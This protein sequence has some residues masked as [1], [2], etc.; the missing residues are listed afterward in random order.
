MLKLIQNNTAQED[1]TEHLL[2]RASNQVNAVV[3]LGKSLA[4]SAQRVNEHT[5]QQAQYTTA[6]TNA[7][8]EMCRSI[9]EIA[10]SAA[11]TSEATA[12]MSTLNQSSL[13][14]M[15]Q[16]AES[17]GAV[18]QLFDR[19]AN[20]MD[21]LRE[22]SSAVSQVV[23][24]ISEIAAQTKLLSMNASIETAHA[25][26]HGRGFAVVAQEVRQ[27]AEKTRDS[28]T[29]ITDVITH[30]LE[31]TEE[32]AGVIRDGQRNAQG[33]VEQANDTTRA[34]LTVSNEIDG[35]NGMIVKI[36][37]AAEEQSA[38]A[39]NITGNIANVARLA[40]DAMGQT[41]S[42]YQTSQDLARIASRLEDRLNASFG[43]EFFGVVP[44]ENAIKLNK[45]F[46][47]LCQVVSAIL[48]RQLYVRLGHDYENA[49][50]DI[51]AGRAL[52][53]YQ[54]PSTYIEAHDR[55]G[56]VPL[57]VPLAKGEP[58]YRSAIVVREESGI[59]SV[60]QLRGKRFAFG[61][62][63]S[64]G[65]K[66]MPQSML[67]DAGVAL[68]DLAAHGFLGSHDNVANAVMQNEFDGGGLM[69]SVAEKY[70][71]KGL[72]IIETS[73][74][75]PQFPLCASPRLTETERTKLTEALVSIQD[76]KVLSSLGSGIS[77][78]APIEDK[79]YDSVRVMLK[80]LAR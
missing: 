37:A 63:K 5:G 35:V 33:S 19:I 48:G 32:M 1:Q 38:T 51:G 67:H 18:S 36:A 29:E 74:L 2:G 21:R 46:A 65:S 20:A 6:L 60:A 7:M 58:Y 73:P 13:G 40:N 64:T 8:E 69:L 24:V 15:Q 17:V 72:K 22:A 61:D 4:E 71:G 26:D 34:L 25:G 70:I 50:K 30:N 53:S 55:Y 49:I 62:P 31:L 59:D 68:E 16:L 79:D 27:L 3:L 14:D 42:S 28:V 80:R 43:M 75:I 52:I 56:V 39:E 76:S 66:A 47:P 44:L 77:G 11:T 78:F 10:G 23:G 41:D 45:S 12:K 9:R 54:T 57:V